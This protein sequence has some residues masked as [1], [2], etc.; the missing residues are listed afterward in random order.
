[1]QLKAGKPP[2]YDRS[3]LN[4]S[5]EEIEKKIIMVISLIGDL[6]LQTKIKWNDLVKGETEVDLASQSDPVLRRADGSY[7]TIFQVLL[8]I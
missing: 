4:L 7:L 8:M 2:I 3:S 5:K 1:M 6:S